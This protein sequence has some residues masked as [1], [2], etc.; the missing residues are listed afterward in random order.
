VKAAELAAPAAERAA[1]KVQ[2]AAQ[3]VPCAAERE[4]ARAAALVHA[5]PAAQ[6]LMHTDMPWAQAALEAAP[7]ARAYWEFR[8]GDLENVGGWAVLAADDDRTFVQKRRPD[9]IGRIPTRQ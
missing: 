1:A 4:W 6:A 5:A 7:W 2:R 8:I 9:P 3:W